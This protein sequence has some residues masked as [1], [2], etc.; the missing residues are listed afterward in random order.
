MPRRTGNEGLHDRVRP[1]EVLRQK[2]ERARRKAQE[3]KELK[4]Y[5]VL[6]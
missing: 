6:P 3:Q 1:G 5:E 4:T 2:H